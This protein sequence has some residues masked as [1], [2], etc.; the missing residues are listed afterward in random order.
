MAQDLASTIGRGFAVGRSIGDDIADFRYRRGSDRIVQKYADQAAAE[1]KA[2]EDYMPQMETELRQL[3]QGMF[4]ADRR[5]VIGRGGGSLSSEVMGGIRDRISTEAGRRIGNQMLANSQN[6]GAA[7]LAGAQAT[8]SRDLARTQAATGDLSGANASLQNQQSFRMQQGVALADQLLRIAQNPKG[9]SD[10][11]AGTWEN[12]KQANPELSYLDT[13]MDDKGKVTLYTNGKPSGDLEPA[14]VAQMLTQYTQKPGEALSQY[15]AVRL[16]SIEEQKANATKISDAYRTARIDVIKKLEAAGVPSDFAS[17]VINAQ[18]SVS[19]SG[20]GLQLKEIGSEPNTYLLEKNGNVYIA[21]TNVEPDKKTGMGGGTMLLYEADGVTP[22]PPAVLEGA[23][24]STLQQTLISLAADQAKVNTKLKFDVLRTQLEA[25]NALQAEETGG[26][27]GARARIGRGTAGAGGAASYRDAIAGIESRGSGDYKAV[28]PQTKTGDRAYGRYQVM[29]NNIPEWTKAA[30]G[31]SMTPEEFLA[32]TE[33]QDAVFDHRFGQY[34]DKFGPEGAARAWFGGEGAVNNPNAKDALGTSVADYG[35]RFLQAIGED[36]GAAAPASTRTAAAAPRA[37]ATKT[38]I[39]RVS[40][41]PQRSTPNTRIT[42]EMVRRGGVELRSKLAEFNQ[43]RAELARF[44][45]EQGDAGRG[46]S[47][48][49]SNPM[50]LRGG[51]APST[52]A[53]PQQ[54]VRQALAQRV[55]Q[56]QSELESMT[57]ETRANTAALGRSRQQSREDA[58]TQA[59]ASR[60][61]GAADFFSRIGGSR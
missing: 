1:G 6:G 17:S 27:T 4:G 41:A 34:I 13:R 12:F 46:A 29:G 30:L 8:A 16:K 28:G 51:A 57:S 53:S 18:K 7:G 44:D 11:W 20:G 9:Q 35:R 2:L 61:G 39:A 55:E 43:A 19:S 37:S 52:S 25:L 54:R 38:P 23:D 47:F 15:N 49:P 60:Y 31:K 5:G 40:A 33:A 24:K 14:E 59:L 3:G 48:D 42:D 10:Q 21:K 45:Q 22:A 26:G 36:G 32:D 50:V 58:D 56:L